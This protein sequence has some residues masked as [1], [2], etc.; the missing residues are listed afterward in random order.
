MPVAQ[1]NDTAAA[2]ELN[3]AALNLMSVG[4]ELF[5]SCGNELNAICGECIPVD[6]DPF[7]LHELCSGTHTAWACSG[8]ACAVTV[9]C[10]LD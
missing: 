3:A 7:A 1:S 6:F 8:A 2:I 4:F 10:F 9:I 5:E